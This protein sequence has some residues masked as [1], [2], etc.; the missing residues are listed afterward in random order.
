[1]SDNVIALPGSGRAA[2]P[3]VPDE[4]LVKGLEMALELARSGQLQS[5]IGTGWTHDGNKFTLWVD[6]HDDINQMLGALN[7][8]PARYISLN[9]RRLP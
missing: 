7:W 5:F 6:S 4:A 9:I 8:L 1:M 3:P 2:A